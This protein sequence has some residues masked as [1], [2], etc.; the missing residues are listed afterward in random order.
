MHYTL[1]PKKRHHG[2]VSTSTTVPCSRHTVTDM[3]PQN[4]SHSLKACRLQ[5]IRAVKPRH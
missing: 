5:Q 2:L 1:I 3:E 4:V